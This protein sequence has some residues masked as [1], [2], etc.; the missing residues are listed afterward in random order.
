M[1]TV[2]PVAD[3]IGARVEPEPLLSEEGYAGKA[4][5]A[6]DRL[7]EIVASGGTPVVC[8]QGGVIPDLVSRVAGAAGITLDRVP[9]KKASVWALSFAHDHAQD[10]GPRLVQADYIPKP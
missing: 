4:E 6:V 9:S 10:S 1:D 3:A 7:L 2:R 5:A 8:S